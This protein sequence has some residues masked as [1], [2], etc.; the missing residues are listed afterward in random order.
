MILLRVRRKREERKL[1][2]AQSIIM[3][4]G[5]SLILT[6]LQTDYRQKLVKTVAENEIK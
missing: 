4:S 5:S 2:M 3:S 1:K 6:D